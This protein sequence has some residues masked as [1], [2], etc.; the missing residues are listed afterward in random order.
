MK[1]FF[2]KLSLVLAA[3]VI[4]GL[5]PATS[6]NAETLKPL[7]ISKQTDRVPVTY[8]ELAVGQSVDYKFIGA[9]DFKKV[10]WSWTSSNTNV[11]TVDKAGVV[12]AKAE[13]TATMTIA[14]PGY[15]PAQ[16]QILV[17]GAQ[18]ATD[19]LT[20]GE[21]KA[22]AKTA[23][24]LAKGTY[25]D[26]A[27]YGAMGYRSG[28]YVKWT[29]TDTNVATVDNKGIVTAKNNGITAI[30]CTVTV[31]ATNK[32]YSG[33]VAVIVQEN[34]P[35]AAPTAIPTAVPGVT[36]TPKPTTAVVSGF[37]VQQ[38]STKSV[39]LTFASAATA[40]S[41]VAI[42]QVRKLA[43]GQTVLTN[44]IVDES[45]TK[46]EGNVLTLF[47]YVPFGEGTYRFTAGN[48]S[49]D[50]ETGIG[51]P[52][53]ITVT[54]KYPYAVTDNDAN[55]AEPTL[56]IRDK[57]GI[58]LDP[59]AFTIYYELV[60]SSSDNAY[61]DSES[62]NIYFWSV[63]VTAVVKVTLTYEE[64]ENTKTVIGQT[65]VKSVKPA[66]YSVDYLS[67]YAVLNSSSIITTKAEADKIWGKTEIIVGE[68]DNY[69]VG[70]AS[71]TEAKDKAISDRVYDDT[72]YPLLT[73]KGYYVRYS[74]NDTT[75]A[76]IDA[77][78]GQIVGVN[79]TTDTKPLYVF[80]TLYREQRA[81]ETKDTDFG[82]IAA[83]PVT[84]KA[85]RVGKTVTLSKTSATALTSGDYTDV[86]IKAETK[87]QYG[88]E[89]ENDTIATV[90]AT[91]KNTNY[92]DDTG[93]VTINGNTFTVHADRFASESVNN[94]TFTVKMHSGVSSKFTLA[95][96]KVPA[97]YNDTAFGIKTTNGTIKFNDK[98][99]TATAE[100][101]TIEI[102][103]QYMGYN[104]KQKTFKW[105]AALTTANAEAGDLYV[106]ITG[107][108]GK[109]VKLDSLQTTDHLELAVVRED[110]AGQPVKLL[111]AGTYTVRVFQVT[112]VASTVTTSLKKTGSFTV[113]NKAAAS[114]TVKIKN[115][116][117]N[118]SAAPLND[119]NC[120]IT[121]N[122]I[123]VPVNEVELVY[124]NLIALNNN[125]YVG[126]VKVRWSP[127]GGG[128]YEV[129]TTIDKSFTVK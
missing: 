43:G 82:I 49:V 80:V 86:E 122:G 5:V 7:T 109:E 70:L 6:A 3:A 14:I 77:T 95:I 28:D 30:I 74:V 61:I 104:Y 40:T 91:V 46:L 73:N 42:Q 51:T 83:I 69:V 126:A 53:T 78:T 13:G 79:A 8:A 119:D 120:I 96:K 44:W 127:F 63:G 105:G 97:T 32:T 16:L 110:N 39:R 41:N 19:V 75:R 52:N 54:Y 76:F 48:N 9:P 57:K 124:P 65:S 11:A 56:T 98:Q 125:V 71:D 106:T 113:V 129:Q 92:S 24:T 66:E 47:A 62:G 87:D 64:G 2:K 58:E 36:V 114:A 33:K 107:P 67:K 117:T 18:S 22:T 31:A 55:P 25:V 88:K 38:T 102:V 84:V 59:S 121:I 60:N 112:G 68:N 94:V 35:T 89:L 103:S 118:N 99:I 4:V 1:N 17:K 45:N 21:T 72:N 26:L 12:T 90:Y 111:A 23:Y 81:N 108:D 85:A 15:V 116:N 101:P 29:S 34:A 50:Y 27:F 115:L 10:G 93:H 100:N 37:T 128:Y 20:L 123:S